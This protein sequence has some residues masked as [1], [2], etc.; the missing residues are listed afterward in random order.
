MTWTFTIGSTAIVFTP[1]LS[2]SL[3]PRPSVNAR[4]SRQYV[5]G[6]NIVHYN[7]LGMNEKKLSLNIRC[8]ITNGNL[9][10]SNI[11]MTGTLATGT[12]TPSDGGTYILTDVDLGIEWGVSDVYVGTITLEY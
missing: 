9:F 1:V 3:R 2:N 4:I 11:G 10:R 5:V 6:T 12:L 8:N 7:V